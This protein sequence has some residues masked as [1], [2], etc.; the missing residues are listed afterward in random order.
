MSLRNEEQSCLPTALAGHAAQGATSATWFKTWDL[1]FRG[2]LHIGL[3][4]HPRSKR[5]RN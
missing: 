1:I 5:R 4:C 3:P 2:P